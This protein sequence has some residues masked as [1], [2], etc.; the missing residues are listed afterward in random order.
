MY[1]PSKIGLGVLLYL[2]HYFGMTRQLLCVSGL[3]RSV[4]TS[5]PIQRERLLPRDAPSRFRPSLL[6]RSTT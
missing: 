3:P 5:N 2:F 1:T 6:I 4:V